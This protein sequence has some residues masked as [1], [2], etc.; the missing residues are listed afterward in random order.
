MNTKA[1][2]LIVLIVII[3]SLAL[4]RVGLFSKQESDQKLIE[5]ALT[6]ALTAAKEGRSG[7]VLDFISKQIKFNIDLPIDRKQIAKFIR[8]NHPDV[9]VVNKTASISDDSAIIVT[10]VKVKVDIIAGNT[11]NQQFDSVTLIFKREDTVQWLIFP[12]KQWRLAEVSAKDMP[13][14]QTWSP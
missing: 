2:L 5:T 13:D 9:Q 7:V 3:G 11:Y 12:S 4:I 14:Y 1:K 6:E 10:P 8:E